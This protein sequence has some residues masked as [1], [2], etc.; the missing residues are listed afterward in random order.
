[1]NP[2]P[3]LVAWLDA[4]EPQPPATLRE[5]MLTALSDS[6]R[7][8]VAV[9]AIPTSLAEAAIGALSIAIE[10]CDERASALDLLA[11]DALLTYAMEAAAE[12]GGEALDA[13]AEAYGNHRLAQLMTGHA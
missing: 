7:D 9:S 11:A 1:M 2:S 13:I 8:S 5:R 6:A 10:K 12:Q 4:R 3:E